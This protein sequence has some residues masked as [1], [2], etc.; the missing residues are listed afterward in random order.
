MVEFMTRMSTDEAP[1]SPNG[2][3]FH[4][5]CPSCDRKLVFHQSDSRMRI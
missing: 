1:C 4:S 2:I 5:N 3:T